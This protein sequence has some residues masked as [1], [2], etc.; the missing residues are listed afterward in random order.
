[1]PGDFNTV[2]SNAFNSGLLLL[3]VPLPVTAIVLPYTSFSG[4]IAISQM[5]PLEVGDV[6][7]ALMHMYTF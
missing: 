1:M 7:I 3:S 4:H 5:N 6:G 2:L